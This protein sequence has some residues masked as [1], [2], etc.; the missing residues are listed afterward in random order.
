MAERWSND[1][2]LKSLESALKGG[3]SA[4]AV[5]PTGVPLVITAV[6]RQRLRE[7]RLLLNH[8]ANRNTKFQN[9]SMMMWAVSGAQC[10]P[11]MIEE[12]H[13]RNVSLDDADSE[14]RITALGIAMQFG[15]AGCASAL[16][17]SGASIRFTTNDGSNA[18]LLAVMGDSVDIT[19]RLLNAGLAANSANLRGFT[20]LMA[21]ANN[22]S[23][24]MI[25]LLIRR[26]ADTC[27]V[28][29]NGETALDAARDP[30][31]PRDSR[32]EAALMVKSCE[33]TIPS[34]PQQE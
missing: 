18:V 23:Y 34:K 12:M 6:Q 17:F 28:A 4:N 26:G 3:L 19:E 9:M 13:S 14:S 11:S 16:M 10:L 1:G 8:G 30:R 15:K 24:P 20:P 27:A 21:A 25:E 7:L 31:L 22:R 2:E 33:R 29:K 5:G 32:I